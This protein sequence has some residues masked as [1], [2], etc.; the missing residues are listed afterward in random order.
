MTSVKFYKGTVI[1]SD[2]IFKL[3]I[4]NL[5]LYRGGNGSKL[6]DSVDLRDSCENIG[7]YRS[8]GLVTG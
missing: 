7:T 4:H 6:G 2:E 5:L 8:C 1:Q 3:F